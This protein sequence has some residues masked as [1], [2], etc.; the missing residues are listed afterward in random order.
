MHHIPSIMTMRKKRNVDEVDKVPM[1]FPKGRRESALLTNRWEKRIQ[2]DNWVLSVTLVI[3]SYIFV[4]KRRDITSIKVKYICC[5]L[6]GQF[7][8]LNWF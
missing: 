6:P 3:T 7:D 1:P 5:S 4:L 2:L 8:F